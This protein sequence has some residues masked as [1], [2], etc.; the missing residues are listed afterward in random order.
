LVFIL[1]EKVAYWNG[2][3]K[4]SRLFSSGKPM[5]FRF[6][7][8][9]SLSFWHYQIA[10]WFLV[11]CADF[12]HI[13]L[14][15]VPSDAQSAKVLETPLAF[16]LSLVLRQIYKGVNYKRLTIL[17]LIG[18]TALWS[19]LFTCICY[20]GTVALWHFILG[21]A[22]SLAFLDF[23]NAI[24]SINYSVPLWLGWSSLYFGI[25]YWRDWE[26]EKYRAEKA[27][28]LARSA[29]LQMLRYQLNP[30]FLFNALNSVRALVGENK[31][32]AK[33]MITELSE[34][35][36]YSLIHR[37]EER[38]PLREELD[39]IRHY[40]SVEKRRFED[41]LDV[42]FTID[43]QATEYPVLGF[44]LHPIVE[45]AIK[46]GM[47]SSPL[48]LRIRIEASLRGE[49]LHLSIMNSGS[50]LADTKR[51]AARHDG[52]GTGLANV[53]SRLENAYPGKH[54]LQVG[55]KDGNVQVAIEI[56]EQAEE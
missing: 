48:P 22:Y 14:G 50:W 38:V 27:T 32:D 13:G 43:P 36:R 35:L 12:V 29:Q 9:K 53:R 4:K 51:Q 34:F 33:A 28:T 8:L 30:H 40:L 2:R 7:G 24:R 23:G 11:W 56:H 52:T 54:H 44:L 5:T 37:D 21:P 31:S 3:L 16:L 19:V 39:A 55:E 45:N 15:V 41:K 47:K 25:K 17:A 26:D 42:R 20:A 18:Y 49:D 1:C 46:Y 10:G 6:P